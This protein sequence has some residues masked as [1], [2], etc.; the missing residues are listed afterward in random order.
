TYDSSSGTWTAGPSL[1][2]LLGEDD[3]PA[4]LLPD[5]NVFFQVAQASNGDPTANPSPCYGTNSLFF[6]WDGA[7]LTEEPGPPDEPDDLESSE[8]RMLVL[9]TGQVLYDAAY[10]QNNKDQDKNLF[11]YNPSGTYQTAW[12]PTI[13]SVSSTL[14]PGSTGNLLQG[15]Q[16]N[17]LSQ[18]AMYGDDEQMASNFP[19]VR[20]T[21]NAT[22]HVF[23]CRTHDFSTMAV[24]TGSQV[25]STQFDVP[26]NVE[27][28]PSTLVVVTNG[29]PSAPAAIYVNGG[30][31]NVTVSPTSLSF[32][33]V[34]GSDDEESTTLTNNG[35]GTLTITSI[36]VSDQDGYM[37]LASS[38]CGSELGQGE[39][40]EATVDFSPGNQCIYGGDSGDLIFFDSGTGGDQ[41]VSLNGTTSQCTQIS[42]GMG[43][44]KLP[45]SPS[46]PAKTPTKKK[47]GG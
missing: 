7:N 29:I 27:A 4:A 14:V 25:V 22:S 13:A 39:S 35:P 6:E 28:G 5:G 42:V 10:Y 9:P 20:I 26:S 3:G 8:G 46:Q 36:E 32:E 33:S 18:G 21:N 16:L 12:Q 44:T 47:G 23:Y 34:G 37:F 15:T 43:A 1:G 11:F 38:T 30:T 31:Q 2:G 24:A 17:G 41:D 40:C 45:P 19:L